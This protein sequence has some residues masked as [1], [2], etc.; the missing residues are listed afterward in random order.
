MRGRLK[1]FLGYAAGVGK[2][3]QMLTEARVAL[4]ELA[5]RHTAYSIESRQHLDESAPVRF[6]LAQPA[7]QLVPAREDAAHHHLPLAPSTTCGRSRRR[8]RT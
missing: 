6:D 5:M 1:I 3:Y 7:V 4:R 8:P 2:T